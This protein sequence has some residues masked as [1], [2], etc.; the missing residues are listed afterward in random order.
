MTAPTREFF[1]HEQLRRLNALVATMAN[2][3]DMNW[4]EDVDLACN[5]PAKGCA[6]DLH[7]VEDDGFVY[8]WNTSCCCWAKVS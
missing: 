3:G 2:L 5:L 6:W 1:D 4:W 7:Y 8:T